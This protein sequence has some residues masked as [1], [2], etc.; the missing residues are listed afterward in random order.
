MYLLFIA[1]IG[2]NLINNKVM[3]VNKS[4]MPYLKVKMLFS[5]KSLNYLEVE[6]E[7]FIFAAY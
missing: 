6:N 5:K 7:C 4:E 3:Y 1:N 2:I